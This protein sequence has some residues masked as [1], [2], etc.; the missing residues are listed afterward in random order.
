MS[1]LFRANHHLGKFLLRLCMSKYFIDL[2]GVRRERAV[3]KR[4]L[5]VETV[6]GLFVRWLNQQIWVFPIVVLSLLAVTSHV[7]VKFW[8]TLSSLRVL[9]SRDTARNIAREL[10]KRAARF[11]PNWPPTSSGVLLR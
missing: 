11:I 1:F 7:P 3:A 2:S 6:I 9:Y 5:F 4:W 8:D 10:G